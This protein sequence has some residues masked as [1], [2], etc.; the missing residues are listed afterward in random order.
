MHAR[1]QAR[2]CKNT[3]I[4][5]L[6]IKSFS[7]KF[8]IFSLFLLENSF[9]YFPQ[10]MHE[11]SNWTVSKL[12]QAHE[13][14]WRNEKSTNVE[15]SSSGALKYATSDKCFGISHWKY[16]VGALMSTITTLIYQD[17]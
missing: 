5:R 9:S 4:S 15:N 3:K 11:F 17:T 1:T 12:T 8:D 2:T 10:N 16:M 14:L 13:F 7:L 6:E